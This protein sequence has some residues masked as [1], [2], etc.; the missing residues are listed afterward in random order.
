LAGGTGWLNCGETTLSIPTTEAGVIYQLQRDGNWV[1]EKTSTSGGSLSFDP[2]QQEGTYNVRAQKVF[3]LNFYYSFTEFGNIILKDA[4]PPPSINF[5]T[6]TSI[7]LTWGG[8][9][10]YIL[11]YGV[12]GFTPGAGSTA[13]AGGTV[14]NTSA[15]TF[16]ING[17]AAGTS[18]DLYVRQLCSPGVYAYSTNRRVSTD[19]GAVG[20]FP[21][22]QG[23]ETVAAGYLPPCW[24]SNFTN[25]DYYGAYFVASGIA[26]TGNNSLASYS[27]S[28][29][30]PRFTLNGNQRLRYYVRCGYLSSEYSIKASGGT[31][32]QSA[33]STVVVTDTI[34][35]TSFQERIVNLTGLTGAV[36]LS[37]NHQ[38]G[39][40]YFDDFVIENIPPCPGASSVK[41]QSTSNTSA[42]IA[43]K[44]SGNF[45]LEYGLSGFTPGT[46]NGAGVGGTLITNAVSPRN[47]SGLL[48]N[49]SYDVYVRQNC[50][51]SGNGFSPN[52]PR[53]NFTMMPDCAAATSISL[54]T[55]INAAIAAGRGILDFSGSYPSNSAGIP[56]PGKELY[57]SFTP[58]TAGVYYL[59]IIS[60]SSGVPSFLYKPA[61]AGCSNSGWIGIGSNDNLAVGKVAIGWLQAGVTYYL[62]LDNG[63]ED[64]FSMTFKVCKSTVA[65]SPQCFSINTLDRKIP[66]NSTKKEYLIDA[67]GD[68]VAE[69]DFATV[70]ARPGKITFSSFNS[71]AINSPRDGSNK[72]YLSRT[73]YIRTDSTL[74]GNIGVKL[75]FNNSDLQKLINE[76][77]DGLA[78]VTTIGNLIATQTA[79]EYCTSTPTLSMGVT[80]P[81]AANGSYDVSASYVQVNTLNLGTFYL[82][83]GNIALSPSTLN[84][85]PGYGV[86]LQFPNLG[87]GTTYRWQVD[88][89]AGFIDLN[90]INSYSG[91]TTSTLG[92]SFPPTSFYG[93]KYRCVAIKD[94]ITIVG[95]SQTMKFSLYWI[96]DVDDNWSNPRNWSC[97]E[98]PDLRVPDANTDVVIP[99][100]FS[101]NSPRVTTDVSCRSLTVEVNAS[102]TIDPGKKIIVTGK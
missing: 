43:W 3:C 21:Q 91:V 99:T 30:L 16:A 82:H 39:T 59:D 32:S 55:N 100:G 78:D 12:A 9:G 54:C 10:N 1:Q 83:G 38:K 52:T 47:I 73:V 49:T 67:T 4:P 69:L 63:Y 94:G 29:T 23:F 6:A 60:R 80:V 86:G 5:T 50:T 20:V 70:N 35:A 84:L 14:I 81:Q 44:G 51:S 19:C 74:S 24:F 11:E 62:L 48:A 7:N 33:F 96:G 46:G 18:Y 53:F 34:D 31:N 22:S 8:T 98:Y 42:T 15:T 64:A 87:S 2:I 27:G 79:F 72:E 95:E 61:S 92:I 90:N 68:L 65:V 26:R 76:P 28:V 58:A 45:I 40:F 57:Y 88:Q 97:S 13:G 101:S 85:C 77:N 93:Y 71:S 75:F 102:I 17:L 36:Y 37:L 25:G 56:T 89:G 66:S 41:L